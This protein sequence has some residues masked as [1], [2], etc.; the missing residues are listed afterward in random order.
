MKEFLDLAYGDRPAM[1][2]DVYLPD[3][4][5]FDM[6]VYFHGGGL[7]AGDK[8][9]K[10]QTAVARE[11]CAHGIGFAS[12]N[13]TLSPEA[14]FPQFIEESAEA[15][16]FVRDHMAEWGCRGRLF[17][18]GESAGAYLTMMLCMDRRY[19]DAVGVDPD[20]IAGWVSHSAQQTTHFRVLADR[21]EDRRLQR[22]DEAA[23]I[24]F[25]NEETRF[26]RLLLL[27][28]TED[29][30]CRYEQNLLFYR[31]ALDFN[32]E[33]KITYRVMEGKHCAGASVRDANGN[34]PFVEILSEF[35]SE[36]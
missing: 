24:W 10:S 18:A 28:Y 6:V 34:L 14:K 32:P 22:V 33:A 3:A 31:A 13:Y 29:M 2:T 23:P 9:S 7:T 36:T 11:T 27:F 15:V 30:P 4:E 5:N 35:V 26:S 12:V 21:G 17:V 1:K 19:L 8:A 25:L 16:R 20:S